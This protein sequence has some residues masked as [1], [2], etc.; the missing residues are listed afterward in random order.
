[1]DVFD[2]FTK[3][4]SRTNVILGFLMVGGILRRQM[5]FDPS[6]EETYRWSALLKSF[7]LI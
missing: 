3:N 2:F 1:M 6:I 7:R 4:E 5:D